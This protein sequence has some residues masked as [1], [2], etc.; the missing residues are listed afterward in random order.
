MK[1]VY[2]MIVLSCGAG[3]QSSALAL[4]ACENAQ[5]GV[6]H[7]NVPVYDAVIFAD[8]GEEPP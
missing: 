3:V 8:L 6:V 4:M 7:Y 2:I 5:K 1:E